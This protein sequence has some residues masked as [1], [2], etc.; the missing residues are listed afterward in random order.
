LK[1]I[2]IYFLKV[3]SE[4]WKSFVYTVLL[5]I[6]IDLLTQSIDSI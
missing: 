3:R 1:K 6:G 5:I 4:N 2:E